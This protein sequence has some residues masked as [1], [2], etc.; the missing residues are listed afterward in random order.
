MIRNAQHQ[1]KHEAAPAVVVMG[2]CVKGAARIENGGDPT[3]P[4]F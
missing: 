3:G 1:P 4:V 2:M